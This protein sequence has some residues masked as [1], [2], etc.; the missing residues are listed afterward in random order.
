MWKN[1]LGYLLLVAAG[2]YFVIFFQGYASWMTL[3]LLVMLPLT[4][5]LTAYLWKRKLKV[6]L[7]V[8]NGMEEMG[9]RGS[10]KI[11]INNSSIFPICKGVCLV[12]YQ[13]QLEAKPRRI[14]IPFY[15][16]ARSMQ[17]IEVPFSCYHCGKI[18][19]QLLR[20]KVVDSFGLFAGRK[21]YGYKAEVC[22]CP[23]FSDA[24]ERVEEL[25]ENEGENSLMP[26]LDLFAVGEC[27]LKEIR[28]YRQGDSMRHIHW[29][30]SAKKKK[31]MS[32]VFEDDLERDGVL[33]FSLLYDEKEEPDFIWYDQ[34]MQELA[35]QAI[36]RS[37]SGRAY[38]IVWYHPE[39]KGFY[40]DKIKD[41]DDLLVFMEKFIKAGIGKKE[42]NFEA[43]KEWYMCYSSA[44]G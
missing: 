37:E 1:R 35:D 43:E 4:N 12:E 17:I 32:R 8:E 23:N 30:A 39:E 15:V 34:R 16:D 44:K 10:L 36:W 33:F 3:W 9:N 19:F 27:E 42:D 21:K 18:E 5:C 7:S 38:E 29:K 24:L 14:S 20:I 2:V 6:S 22:V 26:T 31:L 41:I 13:H 40:K 11:K 28:E 25:V